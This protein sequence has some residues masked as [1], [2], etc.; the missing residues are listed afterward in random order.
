MR[1]DALEANA[2]K[3]FSTNL[4]FKFYFLFQYHQWPPS[5]AM[6][7]SVVTIKALLLFTATFTLA[8]SGAVFMSIDKVVRKMRDCREVHLQLPFLTQ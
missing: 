3:P 2:L 1:S 5:G 8:P 6:L 4:H 7:Y